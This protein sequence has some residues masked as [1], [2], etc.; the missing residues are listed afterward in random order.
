M[1]FVKASDVPAWMTFYV[2]ILYYFAYDVGFFLKFEMGKIWKGWPALLMLTMLCWS[3][4]V[5][6]ALQD[7]YQHV[8]TYDEYLAHQ[9]V[10]LAVSPIAKWPTIFTLLLLPLG[11]FLLVWSRRQR[12]SGMID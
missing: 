8:G 5:T 2:L 9:T 6:R 4:A 10:A 7:R 1:Y 11:I 12:F 3:A